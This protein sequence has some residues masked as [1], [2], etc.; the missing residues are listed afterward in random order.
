MTELCE[1]DTQDASTLV[2]SHLV[3]KHCGVI[4]RDYSRIQRGTRCS[5]CNDLSDCGR[6]AFSVNIHVLVDL[7]QSAYHSKTVGCD[8]ERPKAQ[9]IGTILLF[10]SLR[11]A[12]LNNF[13][14]QLLRAQ[15]VPEHIIEKLLGDNK[16]ASQ[17]FGDLF[18]SVVGIKW[19]KAVTNAE[20]YLD[21]SFQSTSDLMRS[22]ASIRNSFLH[23]GNVWPASRDFATDCVNGMPL[24]A[25]LFVA[26]HNLY[27]HPLIRI[28][29]DTDK[30]AI[31]P[32]KRSRKP[33]T[34]LQAE[35]PGS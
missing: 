5:I 6:L 8:F 32:A 18:A 20:K 33:S 27:V 35:V 24:L 14:V 17:K 12:L 3:C 26:L 22:A 16:L 21:T 15:K 7:V 25:A 19:N 34:A 9:D 29:S 1:V 4:D 2:C 11:E 23:E 31:K 10:C 30:N 13:L 28:A